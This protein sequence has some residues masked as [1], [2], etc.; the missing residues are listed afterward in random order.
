M[1]L[2]APAPRAAPEHFSVKASLINVFIWGASA[3]RAGPEG[4]LGRRTH[5][6]DDAIPFV[7]DTLATVDHT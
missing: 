3:P 1:V 2:G 4:F 5:I 7:D 6:R